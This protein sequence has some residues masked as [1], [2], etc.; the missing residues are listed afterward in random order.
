N[1]FGKMTTEAGSEYEGLSAKDA[2]GKIIIEL[3]KLSLLEKT[4]NYDHRVSKCYRCGKV[5]EP[6]ISK[7]WFLKMD[8]LAKK[9]KEAVKKGEVSFCPKRWEKV[10]FN[11]MDNIKDWCVS[12]QIWW[13]HK[14]PLEGVDDV[15]DTWFS[16]A[17]WPFATLGW[18]EE[19]SSDLKEFYPTQ[20]ISTARDI[21][22]LWV[23]RMIFSSYEFMKQ[24]PF[25]DIIIHPTILTKDG[26][27]MSKSLG[28]GIDPMNLIE[29]Y[30]ADAT[31]F[32][33][34][35]QM[36]GG[37]DIHF[38]EDAIMAGKKF[39]NKL[40]NIARFVSG[41]SEGLKPETKKSKQDEEII[42]K[43]DDIINSVNKDME[44]YKFGQALHTIYDFV[45]HDF[46]DEY[47]EYAKKNQTDKTKEIL[48]ESLKKILTILHPFMPFITEEIWSV[49][50]K[51]NNKFQHL[52]RLK[53]KPKM[54]ELLITKEW[55]K[56]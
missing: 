35:Y 43:L 21:I 27:R 12:R 39:A 42:K 5:I 4:E 31:R 37:Q 47:I 33:L 11:W 36:M 15:L 29:K 50:P 49:L 8:E 7:Q 10:Y 34:I 46:A 19:E 1:Q 26:K 14:I 51:K 22:N 25:T 54:S 55:L 24:K 53:L 23:A 9:A 56:Q 32:G 38:S 20:V 6:Q 28:T 18:P 17:L 52:S 41:Q 16:S 3:E 13:G 48:C 40:W 2:R 30:G 45:W 44:E